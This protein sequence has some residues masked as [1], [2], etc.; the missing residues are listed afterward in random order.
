MPIASTTLAQYLNPLLVET[1]S[2][3]GN[4]TAAALDAGFPRVYTIEAYPALYERVTERFQS[5]PRVMTFSGSSVDRLPEI[6]AEVTEPITIFLDAHA[7]GGATAGAF[8]CPL[9]QELAILATHSI[10]THTILVDDVHVFSLDLPSMEQVLA[11]LRHINPT[12]NYA[13]LPS[14]EAHLGFDVLAAQVAAFR[15]MQRWL[16]LL[17]TGPYVAPGAGMNVP[18][19]M[20]AVCADGSHTV[21]GRHHHCARCDRPSSYQGHLVNGNWAC[22]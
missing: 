18:D 11:G 13:L 8:D 3:L 2:Y 14:G 10:K 4:G 1:G 16:P 17:T 9:L 15:P 7:C 21:H 5:E 19:P 12:Y 22:R 20:I 6:L